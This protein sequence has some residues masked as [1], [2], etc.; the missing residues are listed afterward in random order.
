MNCIIVD[1][2]PLARQGLLR[3]LDG[4]HRISVL[5]AFGDTDDAAAFVAAQAVDVIFLDIEMPGSNGIEFAKT[6]PEHSL[7]IFTTAYPQ[8]ATESYEVDAIDYLLKPLTKEKVDR[9]V[10]KAVQQSALLKAFKSVYE[11]N[12]GS[13]ITIKSER[14]YHR[15]AYDSILFIEGLKDYV[16]LYTKTEKIITAMNLKSFHS[17]LPV[18]DF[19]RVSKSYVVNKDAV[20]SF[21]RTTIYIGNHELPIG[22]AYHGEFQKHFLGN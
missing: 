21:D 6:L 8:Y 17:K 7:I 16:V 3:F 14:R 11:S 4:N 20:E 5:G 15:I 9:A 22:K 19:V 13:Y 18:Q 2:E 12:T 1:D 10:D